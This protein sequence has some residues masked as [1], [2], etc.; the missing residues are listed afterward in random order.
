[1]TCDFNTAFSL[2]YNDIIIIF[3]SSRVHFKI[4][5]NISCIYH[6]VC[7]PE[8]STPFH[9]NPKL[10]VQSVCVCNV[11]GHSHAHTHTCIHIHA[12]AVTRNTHVNHHAIKVTPG[13]VLFM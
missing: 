8:Q 2:L 13:K 12:Y 11:H 9:V 1:M 3:V 6:C 10:H 4:A 5:I 7:I